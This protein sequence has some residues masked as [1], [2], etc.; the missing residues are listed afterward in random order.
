MT[1]GM[2]QGMQVQQAMQQKLAMTPQMLQSMEMLELPLINL[3]HRINEEVAKNPALELGEMQDEALAR[4]EAEARPGGDLGDY[5]WEDRAGDPSGL[6]TR[7]RHGGGDDEERFDALSVIPGRELSLDESLRQQL[8]EL[9]LDDR[10]RALC[11]QIIDSLDE[12]GWFTAPLAQVGTD[13]LPPWRGPEERRETAAAARLSPA[14]DSQEKRWALEVVQSLRPAGVGAANLQQCLALQLDDRDFPLEERAAGA[15]ARTIVLSALDDLAANRLPKIAQDLG[16]SLATVKDATR[17]IRTLDPHPGSSYAARPEAAARPDAVVDLVKAAPG[18][19]DK[20]VAKSNAARERLKQ[21]EAAHAAG[22][23][24]AVELRAARDAYNEAL[25]ATGLFD[26]DGQ[27]RWTVTLAHGVKLEISESFLALFDRTARGRAVRERLQR[28]PERRQEL[29]QL[30]A[31]L[32]GMDPN[33]K[34]KYQEQFQYAQTFSWAL[35]QRDITL[36]RVA[37]AIVAKQ[38]DYLAGRATAPCALLMKDLA[39]DLHIDIST[40]SRAANGKYL[41]TPR[42]MV[43]LRELFTLPL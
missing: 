42:G 19:Y 11:E 1:A 15:T 39:E 14:A 5:R 37:K 10:L 40:V 3:E 20:A 24:D 34:Q 21:V 4:Q 25:T 36:T 32:R 17:I 41:D 12:R 23:A 29:A 30:Q 33:E 26:D 13:A 43:Q 6:G 2:R 28:D 16:V 35:Q 7:G 22:Q 31:G 8:G 38:K 9:K 18:E 27:S